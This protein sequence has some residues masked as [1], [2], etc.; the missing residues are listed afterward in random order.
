MFGNRFGKSGMSLLLSLLTYT[1][2]NFGVRQL[3][4][5]SLMASAAWTS[6]SWWLS[7]LVPD[8]AEAQ[9]I[10]DERLKKDS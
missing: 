10:V 3:S 6:A 5:L 8:Q 7:G 1:F 9:E 4:L 2:G